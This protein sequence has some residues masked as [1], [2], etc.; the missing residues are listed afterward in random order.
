[1]E[2]A[3]REAEGPRCLCVVPWWFDSFRCLQNLSQHR[4]FSNQANARS[5]R[6]ELEI[7]ENRFREF[8]RY[9]RRKTSGRH[10]R[11][12]FG[13]VGERSLQFI[14][15]LA[16]IRLAIR[17]IQPAELRP[18]ALKTPEAGTRNFSIGT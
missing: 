5:K 8:G 13:V 6:F 7:A 1:V 10:R 4:E 11:H 15:R 14:K 17:T 9:W 2:H 12:G 16:M 3:R 18:C